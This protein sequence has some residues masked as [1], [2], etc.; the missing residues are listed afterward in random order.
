MCACACDSV[1]ERRRQRE[2]KRDKIR[3]PKANLFTIQ[4]KDFQPLSKG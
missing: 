3:K 4:L 1:C 2:K